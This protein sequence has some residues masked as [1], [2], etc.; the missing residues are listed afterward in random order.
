MHRRAAGT[1]IYE[2][3][4]DPQKYP[5]EKILAMADLAS[6]LKPDVLPQLQEGLKD[7]DSG[8]R[9]WAAMG[10]LMREPSAVDAARDDLARPEGR[11]AER[12]HHR[13]PGPG[14]IRQRR[15]SGLAL[16]VLKELA[17]PDKNGA[18]VSMLALNAIDAL[19][20]KAASL[21]ET[22]KTMPNNDP[23]AVGRA[24]GYVAR[25]VGKISGCE[26]GK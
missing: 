16:P 20:K 24:N 5:L 11:V 22:L 23:S 8:V 14:P 26:E 25:M 10:L 2:M 9:Y 21:A 4:H 15:R 7:S 12:S 6:S 1:T 18:Y 17:P 19:G 13:R 3:G